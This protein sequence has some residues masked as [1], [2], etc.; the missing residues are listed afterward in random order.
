MARQWAFIADMNHDGAVTISDVGLWLKWLYFYP[1]DLLHYSILSL[2]PGVAQ[3]LELSPS[4]YG[5]W[6]S[7][8]VSAFVWMIV[9]PMLAIFLAAVASSTRQPAKRA[10]TTK[11]IWSRKL[12]WWAGIAVLLPL[13]AL[14]TYF[15]AR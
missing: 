3:F 8:I 15:A 12:P 7:G 5:G 1:G 11:T 10:P 14:I 13:Y 9:L 2:A 4:S 6:G